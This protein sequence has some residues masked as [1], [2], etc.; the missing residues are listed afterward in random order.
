MRIQCTAKKKNNNQKNLIEEKGFLAG[1]LHDVGKADANFQEFILKKIKERNNEVS[2]KEYADESECSELGAEE[3]RGADDDENEFKKPYHHEISWAI[4]KC[5]VNSL[6]FREKPFW[7]DILWAI[8]FHHV[9]PWRKNLNGNNNYYSNAKDII[10]ELSEETIKNSISLIKSILDKYKSQDP[11]IANLIARADEILKCANED[12]KNEMS[13]SWDGSAPN[14]FESSNL[15]EQRSAS[16]RL[17]LRGCL[18]AA[19]RTISGLSKEECDNFSQSDDLT[20]LTASFPGG[21]EKR[22]ENFS[23]CIEDYGKRGQREKEQVDKANE[24]AKSIMDGE[25][26]QTVAALPAGY[27]KT[28]FGLIWAKLIGADKLIWICPRNS[29]AEALF[30][31]IQNEHKEI[32][33]NIK[34]SVELYLT[35]KRQKANEHAQ[36]LEEFSA[37][38]IITNIDSALTPFF[39]HGI[40]PRAL[41]VF[42]RPVIFDEY[43]EFISDSPIFSLF[44]TLM[45]VRTELTAAHTLFLSATPLPF[46]KHWSELGRIKRIEAAHINERKHL[47]SWSEADAPT[48]IPAKDKSLSFFNSIKNA[49]IHFLNRKT[50]AVAHSNFTPKDK[51]VLIKGL[52][53]NLGKEST[54]E[55]IKISTSPI[56]RAAMDIS[57]PILNISVGSP[58]DFM[59][60]IGRLDRWGNSQTKTELHIF[61]MHKNRSEK[62][63]VCS[64]VSLEIFD[65]WRKSLE[66][67]VSNLSKKSDGLCTFSDLYALYWKFL[68]DNE[69]LISKWIKDTAIASFSASD[70]LKNKKSSNKG[71][72]DLDEIKLPSSAGLR[73][74]PSVYS[75]AARMRFDREK[76]QAFVVNKPKLRLLDAT[77]QSLICLDRS[78]PEAQSIAEILSGTTDSKVVQAL[79]DCSRLYG[80]NFNFPSDGRTLKNSF[81]KT[82]VRILNAARIPE[83]PLFLSMPENGTETACR[84]RREY[85]ERIIELI[86]K[87]LVYCSCEAEP[88]NLEDLGP[89]LIDREILNHIGEA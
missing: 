34:V 44:L 38:L 49:Q 87:L 13:L 68:E 47:V 39:R 29:I 19:D 78:R 23:Q 1:L 53:K 46:A 71:N 61:D 11:S 64:V 18:I 77:S 76:W 22:E 79:H 55:N 4:V 86:G 5:L 60:S 73:G 70:L 59:Q 15:E 40:G 57:R 48:R 54:N 24:A 27:G 31:Q 16:R 88:K 62:S 43:H 26:D 9:T 41:M 52:L 30:E 17:L 36:N 63:A 3:D 20:S 58:W 7:E 6:N 66:E 28:R 51:S 72:F 37:D 32:F 45:R 10:N 33:S 89:G 80:E 42:S 82:A 85:N 81:R 74:S 83:T 25:F 21:P 65:K 8:Y 84:A 35:G 56:C 2:A 67:F 75:T 69:S 14:Y 50:D 12:I